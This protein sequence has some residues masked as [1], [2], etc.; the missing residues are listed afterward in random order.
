MAGNSHL[1]KVGRWHKPSSQDL[2]ALEMTVLPGDRLEFSRAGDLYS[3]WGIY[4]GAYNGIEHAVIDFGMFEGGVA[5]S[6]KKA[7]GSAVSAGTKPEIRAN[8]IREVLGTSG[9]VRINNS[10][11]KEQ[12][13]LSDKDI[14]QRAKK[15]HRQQVQIDYNLLQ[16]NCE[17]FV[18]LCR[19]D[20]PT[21]DQADALI[22]GAATGVST[23]KYPNQPRL[24]CYIS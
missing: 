16:S 10:K 22:A 3:H 19:Y 21:S 2:N 23:G 8:S 1:G 5:F 20:K 24:G 13:P 11:D 15:M 18:N 4:V 17:H 6:K 7:S 9:K 14:V 12:M